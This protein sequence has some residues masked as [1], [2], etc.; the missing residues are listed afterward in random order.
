MPYCLLD[1]RKVVINRF[2]AAPPQGWQTPA[3]MEVRQGNGQI[4]QK[5]N[6]TAFVD[7]VPSNEELDADK[8][9]RLGQVDLVVFQLLFRL[10]NDIRACQRAIRSIDTTKAGAA[11][12]PTIA[13]SQDVTLEQ[14]RT[15]VKNQ[16]T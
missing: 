15:Y 2:D 14:F 8:E 1:E 10:V 6:G 11:G 9:R 16:L 12:V 13:Q 7:Y 5:W 4:G 3:G